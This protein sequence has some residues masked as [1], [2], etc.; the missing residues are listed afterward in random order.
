M[1]NVKLLSFLWMT[2]TNR[3]QPNQSMRPHPS[4][5]SMH[6]MESYMKIYLDEYPPQVNMPE[7]DSNSVSLYTWTQFTVPYDLLMYILL[8]YSLSLSL[9][10]ICTVHHEYSSQSY[11][12]LCSHSS[13][14]HWFETLY[15][16]SD[17]VIVSTFLPLNCTVFLQILIFFLYK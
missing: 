16:T 2:S 1:N 7:I 6:R 17:L 4:K 9:I 14:T 15:S 8:T 3:S 12:A 10:C 5:K 11:C 13:Q